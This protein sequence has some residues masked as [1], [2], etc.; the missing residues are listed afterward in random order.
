M[1]AVR[2]GPAMDAKL[3]GLGVGSGERRA[4]VLGVPE[5]EGLHEMTTASDS[6]SESMV[7][8]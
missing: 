5:A 7:T 2:V 3:I 8:P 6:V 1:R 4:D